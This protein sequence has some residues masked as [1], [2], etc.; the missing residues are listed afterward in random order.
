MCITLSGFSIVLIELRLII[1]LVPV[2]TLGFNMYFNSAVR[3][4]QILTVLSADAV[5]TSS[6]A[7]LVLFIVI[8]YAQV[9]TKLV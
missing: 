2:L 8:K 9:L 3:P 5:T 4:S 1:A 6:D 7:L